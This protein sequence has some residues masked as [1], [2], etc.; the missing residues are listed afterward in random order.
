MVLVGAEDILTPIEQSAEIARL[1]P[2]ARLQV[3]P[4]GGRGMVLEYTS[5]TVRAIIA[6]VNAKP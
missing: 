6:S 1:I 2:R 4:R 5:D 3:L